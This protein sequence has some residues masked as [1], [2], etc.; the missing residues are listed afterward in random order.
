MRS[1]ALGVVGV[2]VTLAVLRT[3]SRVNVCLPMIVSV[4]PVTI[5]VLLSLERSV[6][7][8]VALLL[9]GAFDG[10]FARIVSDVEKPALLL[11]NVVATARRVTS[12][13]LVTLTVV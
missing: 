7:E 10:E 12:V 5:M 11:P 9:N 4:P 8:I 6:A 13:S 2:D 1:T 3:I